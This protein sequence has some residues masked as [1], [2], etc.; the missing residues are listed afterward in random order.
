MYSPKDP[1]PGI[2]VLIAEDDALTREVVRQ[3]LESDGLR[4]AEAD[5]GCSAVDLARECH[6]RLALLDVMMPGMDGFAVARQ[7]RSDPRTRDIRINFM[8][9]MAD[10]LARG[11]ARRA[12]GECLLSKPF[13]LNDLVDAVRVSLACGPDA[14]DPPRG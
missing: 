3:A 13:D 14:A 11:A 7:L 9:A 10:R 2:D 6:P 4:C 1:D 8:T 5:D 12:G